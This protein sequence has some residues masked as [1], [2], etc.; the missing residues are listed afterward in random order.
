MHVTL[1]ERGIVRDLLRECTS[2]KPHVQ[3][4]ALRFLGYAA[5]HG[6][7]DGELRRRRVLITLAEP[8]VPQIFKLYKNFVRYLSDP[9]T[10]VRLYSTMILSNIARSDESCRKLLSEGVCSKL[11]HLLRTEDNTQ[12]HHL[13]AGT[14]RNLAIPRA[15]RGNA[16]VGT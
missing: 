2:S 14:L 4:A 9:E 3:Q 16:P 1:M 12:F 6:A 8:C 10:N 7:C 11:V 15:L 5:V 13:C